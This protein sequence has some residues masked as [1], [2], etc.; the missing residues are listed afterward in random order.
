MSESV[1]RSP[2]ELFWTAKK[3]CIL[4]CT[5]IF[6]TVFCNEI[7]RGLSNSERKCCVT[8]DFEQLQNRFESLF[9]ET[10]V[11]DYRIVVWDNEVF[12]E[13]GYYCAVKPD[14][15]RQTNRSAPHPFVH[16]AK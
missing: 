6:C 8:T 13:K 12:I 15:D 10:R 14:V 3:P 9:Q 7:Q 2:I 5:F 16:C 11:D 1:T 4:H